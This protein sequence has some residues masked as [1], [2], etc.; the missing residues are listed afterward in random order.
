MKIETQDA[1]AAV[2]SAKIPLSLKRQI[3]ELAMARDV[4]L[5]VVV[6]EAL[7]EYVAAH[8]PRRPVPRATPP[9]RVPGR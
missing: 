2:I 3:V 7:R 6:E 1:T 5:G 4:S 9:R 8:P